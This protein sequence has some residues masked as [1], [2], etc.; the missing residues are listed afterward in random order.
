MFR[1]T[2][3]IFRYNTYKNVKELLHAILT[4]FCIFVCVIPEDGRGRPKHVVKNTNI[5]TNIVANKGILFL[6]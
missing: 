4:D 3:A 2:W 5:V 1:P 6:Y